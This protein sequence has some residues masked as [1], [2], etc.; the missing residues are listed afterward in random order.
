MLE[1]N[2][3][4]IR[5]MEIV[6]AGYSDSE[7]QEPSQNATVY[8]TKTDLLSDTTSCPDNHVPIRKCLIHRSA[9]HPI[10]RCRTFHAMSIADRRQI[11]KLNNACTHCLETDHHSSKCT[12]TFRC[13]V[14]NCGSSSHNALL[15]DDSSD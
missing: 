7:E 6:D 4:N 14:A 1:Y 2:E 11:V 13:T 10:W 12:K 15:H 8:Y 3:A 9:D 5:K